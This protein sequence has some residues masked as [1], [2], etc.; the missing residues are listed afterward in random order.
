MRGTA[1][2]T[3]VVHVAMVL[4]AFCSVPLG[5]Q[6]RPLTRV[7]EGRVTP[8]SPQTYSLRTG[9]GDL[10]SGT[11]TMKDGPEIRFDVYGPDGKQ[12]KAILIDE[13]GETP[14]GF[15]APVAGTYRLQLAAPTATP[16]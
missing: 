14:V 15:V 12:V 16:A 8:G 3:F 2:L 13:V 5:A 7:V 9:A 11:F 10:T 6:E 4:G 1:D